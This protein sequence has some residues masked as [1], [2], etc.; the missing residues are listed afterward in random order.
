MAGGGDGAT[1]TDGEM[2][3]R[4]EPDRLPLAS[5]GLATITGLLDAVAAAVALAKTLDKRGRRATAGDGA[6]TDGGF[7]LGN[8]PVTA[9]GGFRWGWLVLVLVNSELIFRV[10]VERKVS[11]DCGVGEAAVAL[12]AT[13]AGWTIG[14]VNVFDGRLEM[15]MTQSRALLLLAWTLVVDVLNCSSICGGRGGA[16]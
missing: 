15:D 11:A 13:V 12:A 1:T 9:D 5:L 3:R 16:W 8:F 2:P 4:I 6:R 14:W 10:N 7:E